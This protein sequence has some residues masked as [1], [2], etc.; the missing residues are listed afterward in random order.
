MLDIAG[1]SIMMT[2]DRWLAEFE[3]AVSDSDWPG[4]K[5]L[6]HPESHWRDLLALTW[7]IQTVSG[8]DRRATNRNLAHCDVVGWEPSTASGA[9]IGTER[10]R[11]QDSFMNSSK[12]INHLFKTIDHL[13][14][15]KYN[16]NNYIIFIS[17][18][19]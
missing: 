18:L 9:V 14:T 17:Y 11:R 10:N 16:L 13:L 6:L 19:L 7:D 2:T 1:D 15:L 8:A 4:V 3:T 12:L 5:A